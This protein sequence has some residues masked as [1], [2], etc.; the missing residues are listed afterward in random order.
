M[1]WEQGAAGVVETARE[2]E[3]EPVDVTELLK[4]QDKILTGE[5][6]LLM[7]EER[8]WFLEMELTPHEEAVKTV[9]MATEDVE[10][11]INLADKAAARSERTDFNPERSSPVSKM[12]PSS[13]ACFRGIVYERNTP[14]ML[15]I[16]LWPYFKK[17]PHQ[18]Q[19]SLE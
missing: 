4:S 13:N 14:L 6:V 2:L 17:L 7:N 9:E 5:E 16:S 8:K 11:D 3:V 15:H 10:Y 18:P 12:L 19:P 1:S